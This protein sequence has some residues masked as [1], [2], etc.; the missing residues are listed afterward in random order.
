MSPVGACRVAAHPA[1]RPGSRAR[2]LRARRTEVT[3]PP[4]PG[5]PAR[6]CSLVGLPQ[7]APS[8]LRAAG[9]NSARPEREDCGARL[10]FQLQ[11][12]RRGGGQRAERAPPGQTAGVSWPD[13]PP[14]PGPLPDAALAG[15]P[16]GT[17]RAPGAG[18]LG[19]GR[20]LPNQGP[21]PEGAAT[22]VPP[23]VALLT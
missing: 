1:G 7:R 3:F 13:A 22:V 9:T 19:G 2:V 12:C 8:R 21:V 11:P 18:T 15:H 6:P 5:A 20:S 14:P 17:L 10:Q 4:L 16:C 23:K